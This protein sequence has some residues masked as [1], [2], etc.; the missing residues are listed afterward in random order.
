MNCQEFRQ[1]YL[2]DPRSQDDAFLEHKQTCRPCAEF[3]AQE[4]AFEQALASAIAIPVPENLAARVVLSQ[5]VHSTRRPFGLAAAATLLITVAVTV[6]LLRPSTSSLEHDVIAHIVDEREHLTA[7]ALVSDK[8]VTAVFDTLGVTATPP[9]TEVRYAGVCPI[10]H[11]PGGHL[12]LAGAQ[13]PVTLLFMPR[14]TVGRRLPIDAGGF[15][16]IIV[17]HGQG[18][19]AIVGQPGEPLDD[20]VRQ[21]AA[22]AEVS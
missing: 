8:A 16:G 15:H 7:S 10:R 3:A 18:S 21:L 11:Q 2:T 5:T 4:A 14:E 1:L 20:F 17:P 9:L 22:G 13:G 19:V 6:T 12:I